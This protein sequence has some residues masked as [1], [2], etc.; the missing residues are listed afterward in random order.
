MCFFNQEVFQC[1]DWKW[2][3]RREACSRAPQIGESC[4][5]K[6]IMDSQ[7]INQLCSICQ[8]IERKQRRIRKLEERIKRWNREPK[9]WR[10]SIEAAKQEMQDIARESRWLDMERPTR[11]HRLTNASHRPTVLLSMCHSTWS[12][13]YSRGLKATGETCPCQS[14]SLEIE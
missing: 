13:L 2:G 9:Q 3:S 12:V 10:A 8:E 4:G 11:V 7:H 14:V 6:L 1:Q 5:I